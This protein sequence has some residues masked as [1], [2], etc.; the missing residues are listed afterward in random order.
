MARKG[1]YSTLNGKC[2]VFS[3]SVEADNAPFK[4]KLHRYL[5]TFIFL[6]RLGMFSSS[7]GRVP[8]RRA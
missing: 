7:N 4:G 3:T 5:L 1:I 2:N 6:N 8:Q